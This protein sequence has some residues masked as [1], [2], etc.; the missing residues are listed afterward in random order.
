MTEARINRADRKAQ[1]VRAVTDPDTSPEIE[2]VKAVFDTQAGWWHRHRKRLG[3]IAGIV[4][5]IA[6]GGY[7]VGRIV[8]AAEAETSE[9]AKLVTKIERIDARLSHI[10]GQLQVLITS[11]PKET[12]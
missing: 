11:M 3:A 4:G 2:A 5:V 6:G 1:R 9:Q 12:P 10:E 8:F 7:A